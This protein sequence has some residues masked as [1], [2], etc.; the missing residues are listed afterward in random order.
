MGGRQLGPIQTVDAFD[1]RFADGMYQVRRK[2]GITRSQLSRI[3][4]LP[5]HTIEK[6]ETGHGCGRKGLR[7]RATIGEA[8]VLAE[9]LGMT[10]GDLLRAGEH[11]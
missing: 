2:K 8:I 9:A 11:R 7:R 1:N 10:P 6:M 5:V 4:G 3:T